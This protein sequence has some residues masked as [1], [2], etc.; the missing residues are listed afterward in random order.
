MRYER[1]LLV[2]VGDVN[3]VV[4]GIAAIGV[5]PDGSDFPIHFEFE[6]DR[7]RDF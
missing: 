1:P 7:D 6:E 4:L 2:E 5:D 3:S